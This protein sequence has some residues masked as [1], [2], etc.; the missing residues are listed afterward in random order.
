MKLNPTANVLSPTEH[1]RRVFPL[2]VKNVIVAEAYAAPKNIKKTARKYNIQANQIRSWN[3][4]MIE[5]NEKVAVLTPDSKEYKK[6]VSRNVNSVKYRRL[7]GAGR[8]VIFSSLTIAHLKKYVDDHRSIH[9]PVS[10]QSIHHQL[11]KFDPN[12]VVGVSEAA[13]THRLYRLLKKWNI[14]WRRKTH[15]AQNTRHCQDVIEEF[16]SYV[17]KKIKFLRIH[18]D[19]IYN[20]D[21]T[22]VY[23]SMES[24]Y[25]YAETGSRSVSIRGA[26]SAQRCTVM[27]AVNASGSNKLPPYIIFKGAPGRNGRIIR[28]VNGKVGLPAECEYGVQ[29]KAWMDEPQML[30]WIEV[31]WKPFTQARDNV[32]TYLILDECRTHLTTNVKKAFEL[33]NTEVEYIPGGYTSKLQVLDVGINKPFKNYMRY[34]FDCWMTTTT[35]NYKPQ[36]SNVAEWI[37]T[38]WNKVT[39][40]TI[41]NTWNKIGFLKE[42]LTGIPTNSL[43]EA[44]NNEIDTTI[45]NDNDMDTDTDNDD[46][47][48][49][50]GK[51]Y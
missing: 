4:F 36:R 50:Y 23:Y 27:L 39:S 38:A 10:L 21:Q 15:T 42:V 46:P 34:E 51:L 43:L 13:I 44:D 28:E 7:T 32:L 48:Q 14:S 29:A 22:N 12:S 9:L 19:N 25:T 31:V 45:D 35:N 49:Y 33:L 5:N 20:A 11:I 40:S 6:F 16:R 17:Q 41:T 37:L 3:K 47:L 8:H 2:A 1:K 26:E 24:N 30:N 18:P